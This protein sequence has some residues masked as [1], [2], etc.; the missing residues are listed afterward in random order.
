MPLARALG[1]PLLR[2]SAVL[3]RLLAMLVVLGAG[4]LPFTPRL[5]AATNASP[6]LQQKG[7]R[8]NSLPALRANL[9]TNLPPAALRSA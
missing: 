4:L 2:S 7:A 9:R 3:L 6:A 8:T 5:G 1:T